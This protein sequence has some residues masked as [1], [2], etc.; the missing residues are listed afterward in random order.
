MSLP[1]PPPVVAAPPVL[2]FQ[3][4]LLRALPGGIALAA[5]LLSGCIASVNTRRCSTSTRTT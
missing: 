4:V 2:G 5:A 1:A 3:R